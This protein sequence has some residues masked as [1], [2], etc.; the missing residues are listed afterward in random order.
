MQIKKNSKRCAGLCKDG[1]KCL[2]PVFKDSLC[3]LHYKLKLK[4]KLS[5]ILN[6]DSKPSN[7]LPSL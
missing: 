1:S 5:K 4:K 7:K 3:S 2:N 6:G